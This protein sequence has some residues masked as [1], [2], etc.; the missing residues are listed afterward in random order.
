M[1]RIWNGLARDTRTV[2]LSVVA[3]SLVVGVPATAAVVATNS[4]KVDGKHAVGA[5]AGLAKRARKLVATNARGPLPA[6]SRTSAGGELTARELA[7]LTLVAEGR[8]NRDVAAEL[9]VSEATVKTHLRHVYDKLGV[10]DRAG[11]VSTAYR[12]GLLGR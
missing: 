4:D 12:K 8:A 6:N 5:K 7:V 9:F 3:S 1:G 11:A 2:I 10:S